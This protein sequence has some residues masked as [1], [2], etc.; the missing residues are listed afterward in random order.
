MDRRTLLA[1]S[2]CLLA[3]PRAGEAQLSRKGAQ[4]RARSV[5]HMTLAGA[6]AELG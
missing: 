5:A 1:G 2:V 6:I 4:A 3:A